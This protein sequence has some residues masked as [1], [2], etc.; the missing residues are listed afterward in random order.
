MDGVLLDTESISKMA[1]ERAFDS[2]GEKLDEKTYQEILGRSLNDISYFLSEMLNKAGLG[3]KS[4]PNVI[5][6]F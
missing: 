1:F 6:S 5:N 3:K 4:W 2:V